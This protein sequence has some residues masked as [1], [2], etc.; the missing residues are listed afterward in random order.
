MWLRREA[1]NPKSTVEKLGSLE[2]ELIECI[3]TRGEVSV[4][5]L[6]ADF[7]SRLAYTTVMTTLDRLY[8]KGLL[9][10]RKVGKAYYYVSRLTRDEYHESLTHHLLAIIWENGKS[11]H[12]VLSSFV[13]VVG[14]TDEEMLNQLDQLV[15]AKRRALRQQGS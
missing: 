2:S 8:K 11:S 1:G 4:R 14:G 6:H 9:N 5:D 3:W 15:K 12:D 10:R 13:D 7:S